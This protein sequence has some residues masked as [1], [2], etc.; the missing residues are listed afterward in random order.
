MEV[1]P[2]S[3]NYFKYKSKDTNCQNGLKENKIQL[4]T[5]Y[6]RHFRSKDTECEDG[7]RYSKQIVITREQGWIW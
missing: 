3:R 6:R 1:N 2:F 4:Y 7:K 5:V